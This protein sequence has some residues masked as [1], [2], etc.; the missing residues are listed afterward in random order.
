MVV[1]LYTSGLFFYLLSFTNNTTVDGKH[2]Y[3]MRPCFIVISDDKVAF[4]Q[5]K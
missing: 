5:V 1:L 3:N 2:L 4:L